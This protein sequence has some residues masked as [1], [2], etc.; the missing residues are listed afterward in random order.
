MSQFFFFRTCIFFIKKKKIGI[1][2]TVLAWDRGIKLLVVEVDSL[3]VTQLLQRR[4]DVHN[5][6]YPLVKGI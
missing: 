2:S 3:C 6:C 5:A 1:Y 4:D